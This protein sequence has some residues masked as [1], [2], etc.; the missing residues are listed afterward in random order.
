MPLYTE[1][2]YCNQQVF[3]LKMSFFL[4]PLWLKSFPLSSTLCLIASIDLHATLPTLVDPLPHSL[5]FP[6]LLLQNFS[7]PVF[8]FLVFVPSLY[9]YF[10]L[11]TSLIPFLQFFYLHSLFVPFLPNLRSPL[12]LSSLSFA[13]TFLPFSILLHPLPH[14]F[15]FPL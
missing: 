7:V 11:T 15:A 10:S 4:S 3:M 5:L 12:T 14:H 8:H 9:L 1:N 13:T 6:I 2:F